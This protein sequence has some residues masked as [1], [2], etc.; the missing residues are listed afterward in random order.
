MRTV[1]FGLINLIATFSVA[2]TT[3][4]I[5]HIG[6][7]VSEIMSRAIPGFI[8]FTIT[9]GIFIRIIRRLAGLA[10]PVTLRTFLDEGMRFVAFRAVPTV[11]AML[12]IFGHMVRLLLR[13]VP[14]VRTTF[15]RGMYPAFDA[16][17]PIAFLTGLV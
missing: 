10:V 3:L 14:T 13:A 2:I 6:I 15:G 16:A 11:L 7:S 1:C 8:L 5:A 12:C 17:I 4:F 9:D